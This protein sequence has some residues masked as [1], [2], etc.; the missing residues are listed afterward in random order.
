MWND[1]EES[2]SKDSKTVNKNNGK[3]FLEDFSKNSRIES[4]KKNGKGDL[5]MEEKHGLVLE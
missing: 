5:F 4:K 1:W 2:V 3:I